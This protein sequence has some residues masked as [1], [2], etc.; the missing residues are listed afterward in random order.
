MASASASSGP[1]LAELAERDATGEVARIYG[2]IRELCA[3]P[4]V[5]SMQRHLAT[6]PGWLPWAW[7][8]VRPA[9]VDG[10]AQEAAWRAAGPTDAPPLPRLSG[11]ALRVLGVDAD[12]ER[13]IRA[14]CESFVRVSPTN[15]MFS[16]LLRRLLSGERPGGHESTG[17]TARWT[18]P[19]AL[20]S[21]PALVDP[22]AMPPDQSAVLMELGTEVGG[23]PFVP[24]LYRMLAHWP[25]YLAHVA[26]VLRPR[27]DDP[28]TA[29]SCRAAL[30]RIDAEVPA[31]FAR[32]PAP[33]PSPAMPPREEHAD[34]LAAL[35]RYRG[36][37]PQMIVLGAL[38]RDALPPPR[39]A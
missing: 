35:D 27:F 29:A 5:S 13:S 38:L 32:L 19:A 31:V 21:L 20:P 15:L 12:A 33:P 6:R 30:A 10:S 3:V 1:M 23:R 34:V 2:E 25:A 9:F 26:T 24:G 17:G 7:A 4:Y 36:T 16:G 22:A 18:P 11:S 39:P 37:S 28:A 8:A 14:T